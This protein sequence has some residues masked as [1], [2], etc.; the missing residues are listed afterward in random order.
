VKYKR[1][2]GKEKKERRIKVTVRNKKKR[3]K[4]MKD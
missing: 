2:S 1:R 4:N 3:E